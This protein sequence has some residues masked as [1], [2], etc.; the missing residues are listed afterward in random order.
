MTAPA[1]APTAARAWPGNLEKQQ[2][3]R[4]QEI[5]TGFH[6]F[7]KIQDVLEGSDRGDDLEF[8]PG[9]TCHLGI[10]HVVCYHGNATRRSLFKSPGID[11]DPKAL[12]RAG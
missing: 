6:R 11:L 12:E 1:P 10:G 5:K 3:R 8:P 4:R 9:A 7:A 2:A